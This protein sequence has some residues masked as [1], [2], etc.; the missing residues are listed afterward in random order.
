MEGGSKD[1]V[2][3]LDV[4]EMNILDLKSELSLLK[5]DNESKLKT[6]TFELELRAFKQ[7]VSDLD[8]QWT[9]KLQEL[10][11]NLVNLFADKEQTRKKFLSLEKNV[12]SCSN[13]LDKKLVRFGDG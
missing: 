3:R 5:E 10:M 13:C 7:D 12:S 4:A 2:E 8:T 9:D 1:I 6:M 11:N